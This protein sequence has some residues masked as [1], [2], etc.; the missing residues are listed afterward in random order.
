MDSVHARVA[1]RQRVHEFAGAIGR[2]VVHDDHARV[3][4]QRADFGNQ[5]LDI[6][7][8][9][10][11]GMMTAGGIESPRKVRFPLYSIFAWNA[12]A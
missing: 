1:R 7:A 4:W 12:N 5:A 11:V 6:V 9:V 3:Q 8:F 10:V 2:I